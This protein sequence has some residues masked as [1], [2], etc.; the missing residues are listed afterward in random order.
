MSTTNPPDEVSALQE[1]AGAAEFELTLAY[2]EIAQKV[3][4]GDRFT[5]T[6]QNA[7]AQLLEVS[8]AVRELVAEAR[9]LRERGATRTTV[10]SRAHQLAARTAELR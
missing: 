7:A 1:A 9:D 8:A 6:Q 5:S 4:A 3:A 10:A 2:E